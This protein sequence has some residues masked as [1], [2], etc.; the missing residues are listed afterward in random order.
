MTRVFL[1]A[2]PGS[3]RERWEE[4]LDT[5]DVPVV[6]CAD[7]LEDLDEELADQAEIILIDASATSL[8][9]VVAELEDQRL[10]R[11]LRVVLL[12]D[13]AQAAFVN[14]AI[15]AGIR[16]ILPINVD[17]QQLSAALKAI[18]HG[19]VVLHPSELAVARSARASATDFAEDVE[20]LTVR[21]RD[22]LQMLAQ[23]LANKEIA[24]RLGISEHTVKFHV[25]SILGKLGASTRTEAVSIALRRGLILL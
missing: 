16:G 10:I 7:D 11:E 15:Q 8:E 21:E 24:V 19:F 18:G 25:A 12:T 13:Q 1:I 9:D 20:A 2:A 17:A 3:I 14:R 6:G 22:V 23:G 4:Q 5:G